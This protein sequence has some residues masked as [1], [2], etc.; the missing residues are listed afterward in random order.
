M[1]L[2]CSFAILAACGGDVETSCTTSYLSYDNFGA[3]FI[4]SWCRGCHSGDVPPGMRQHA[5]VGI[6]FDTLDEVRAQALPIARTTMVLR[7][8]PPAGGPSDTER[9][10]L[11]EWLRC[12]AR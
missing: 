11:D 8:M 5:P 2:W 4:A 9:A 7:T 1:R 12:G 10:M 6:D 3:L